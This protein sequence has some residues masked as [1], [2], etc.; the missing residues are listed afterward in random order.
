[1]KKTEP[2]MRFLIGGALLLLSLL[3]IAFSHSPY[4][5]PLFIF[6]IIALVA[7]ALAEFYEIAKAKGYRPLAP[8]AIASS[9][10]LLLSLP[11]QQGGEIPLLL[12]YG[13]MALSFGHFLSKGERPLLNLSVTF[14]GMAYL[15]L[16][17]ACILL[18][19]YMQGVDG[20]L[21]L[22]Y[23]LLVTKSGDIA[24]YY[25]GSLFGKRPL[26][27]FVSPKKTVEGAA[28]GLAGSLL[29]SLLFTT[30]FP[31]LNPLESIA[32]GPAVGLMGQFGDLSESLLKRDALVK[33]SNRIPGLGGI[34]DMCD[35]LVFTLP[36]VYFALKV[37]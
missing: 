30:L 14:F 13:M 24:A 34:L 37:I 18:I 9:S 17:L 2:L 4:V 16:P 12:L 7:V 15:T 21:W 25:G 22:L 27:P 28:F 8:L 23:T 11:F 1:M 19:N 33:D 3:L 20:R 35:S 6:S 31:I 5:K 29:V 32:L 36:I 10:L 26:A